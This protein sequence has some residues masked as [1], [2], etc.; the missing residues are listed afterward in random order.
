MYEYGTTTECLS[1]FKEKVAL[2]AVRGVG[3]AAELSVRDQGHPNMIGK[4]KQCTLT[5]GGIQQPRCFRAPG[6]WRSRAVQVVWE[7]RGTGV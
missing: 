1:E 3:T 5:C 4:R 2:V 7:T 6:E